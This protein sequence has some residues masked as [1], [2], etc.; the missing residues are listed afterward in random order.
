[1]CEFPSW[2]EKD[3]VSYWNTD[4]L[5]DQHR[6]DHKDGVGHSGIRL[7]W[8]IEGGEE[9]EFPEDIPPEM[10]ADVKSGKCR[11]MMKAAGIVAIYYNSK[12]QL[13]RDNGPAIEKADGS[14]YWYRE[15]GRH[16]DDGPAIEHADGFKAWYRDGWLHRDRGPAVERP[17][18][19]EYWYRHGK[20]H[21]DDG[22]AI[23]RPD[24]SKYWYR[25]GK[26]VKVET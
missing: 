10:G 14:K 19:S 8:N 18:G 17:D 7:V 5:L 16:R 13:H 21:R 15:G 9:H 22:P 1:M 4:A 26:F 12:G 25:H 2:I 11:K 20:F 24:G 6:I 3:G 23:E